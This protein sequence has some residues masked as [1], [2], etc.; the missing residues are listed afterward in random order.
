[1]HVTPG[2][3]SLKVALLY[4]GEVYIQEV[5]LAICLFDSCD[6]DAYLIFEN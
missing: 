4:Y 5:I 3:P 6:K 2:N 1:M